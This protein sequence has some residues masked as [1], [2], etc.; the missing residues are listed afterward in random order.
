MST[1]TPGPWSWAKG[2]EYADG[3]DFPTVYMGP[4]ASEI[5]GA[6]MD[7]ADA[8][9]ALIAAAPDLLAA[10]KNYENADGRL[11]E[12]E[13]REVTLAAIAKAGDSQGNS[14]SGSE[15]ALR[16]PSE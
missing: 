14:G 7:E 2:R 16:G 10:L 6:T 4:E 3:R 11:T 12:R 13:R 5:G 1:H 9:A 8:N 15:S